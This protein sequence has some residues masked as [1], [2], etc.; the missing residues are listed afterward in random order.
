MPGIIYP[1]F[2]IFIQSATGAEPEQLGKRK[3]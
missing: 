3:K 2:F 1:E